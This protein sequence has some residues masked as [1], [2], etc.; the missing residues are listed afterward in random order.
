MFIKQLSIFVEN[1]H[2]RLEAIIDAMCAKGVNIRALSIADTTDFG[3]LRVIV[4]D[5]EKAKKALDEI[6]VIAKMTDVVAVYIDDRTGGLHSILKIISDGG[7]SV[8]Y[9]YAF[10]GRTEG[11]ALMVLKADDEVKAEQLLA[12]NGIVCLS[13][14]DI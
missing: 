9:M 13:Q 4:D 12:D 7:V 1:K 14:K 5:N 6:G 2:G 8:E 11:K 10:L 3:V